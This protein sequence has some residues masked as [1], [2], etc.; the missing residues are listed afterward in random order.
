MISN[1]SDIRMIGYGAMLVEAVVSILALIAATAMLPGDYF[2][3]N[4][5][6]NHFKNLGLLRPI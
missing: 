5:Q 4:L 3:I 6:Q 1:E 2:A